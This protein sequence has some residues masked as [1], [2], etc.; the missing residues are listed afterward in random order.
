MDAMQWWIDQGTDKCKPIVEEATSWAYFVH[1]AHKR[2][3]PG[4]DLA[5]EL[6]RLSK[7]AMTFD[8]LL[9]P[10][11]QLHVPVRSSTITEVH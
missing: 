7:G 10:K 2:K 1:I 6:V 5:R 3:R 8:E 11:S 9:I 4:P